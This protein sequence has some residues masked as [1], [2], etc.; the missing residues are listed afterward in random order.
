MQKSSSAGI[1][2]VH[3]SLGNMFRA[4]NGQ[5]KELGYVEYRIL[6]SKPRETVEFFHTYTSPDARGMGVGADVVQKGLE[7]AKSNMYVVIPSCSYVAAYMEKN[8]QY[9]SLL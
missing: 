5:G 8:S 2:V 4:V 3:D 7:W 6:K 9:K 1:S